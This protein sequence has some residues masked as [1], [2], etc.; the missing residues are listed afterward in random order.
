MS[1]K[2]IV[3]KVIA[4]GLTVMYIFNCDIDPNTTEPKYTRFIVLT[5]EKGGK[6]EVINEGEV[7][8]CENGVITPGIRKITT[9]RKTA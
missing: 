5:R 4:L 7:L 3:G 9:H 1:L 6:F 8:S 2:K